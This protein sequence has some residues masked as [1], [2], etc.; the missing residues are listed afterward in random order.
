MSSGIIA[1]VVCN[2]IQSLTLMNPVTLVTAPLLARIVQPCQFL[3][4]GL[5]A[6]SCS[7]AAVDKGGQNSHAPV[8]AKHRQ[9]LSCQHTLP[10]TQT[11]LVIADSPL[12]HKQEF[13]L[14]HC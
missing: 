10:C 14:E 2:N 7:S 1:N 13:P 8:P 11:L 3:E 9:T 12:C 5:D 4:V 6:A